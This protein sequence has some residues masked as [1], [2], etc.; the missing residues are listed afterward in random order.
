MA[1][2]LFGLALVSSYARSNKRKALC[3][4][5]AGLAAHTSRDRCRRTARIAAQNAKQL[6]IWPRHKTAKAVGTEQAEPRAGSFDIAQRRALAKSS[7]SA[8]ES[9]PPRT[10]A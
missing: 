10:T 6:A 5:A 7:C 9:A 1:A 3:F 2:Y 8:P 4:S